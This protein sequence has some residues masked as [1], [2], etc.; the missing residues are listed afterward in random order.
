MMR[1]TALILGGARTPIGRYGG[2]LSPIR[3]DDLL[4]LAL[5]A[6]VERVG[7]DRGGI[8][9]IAAGCVD[10]AHEGMGNVARCAELRE[11]QARYGAIGICVGSEQGVAVVLEYAGPRR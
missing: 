3:T 6:A 2:S 11:R 4:G 9:E 1:H 7:V 5:T 10:A 8:D